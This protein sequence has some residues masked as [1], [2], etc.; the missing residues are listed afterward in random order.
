MVELRTIRFTVFRWTIRFGGTIQVGTFLLTAE[1][2]GFVYLVYLV[3]LF[4]KLIF[5]KSSINE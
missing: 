4:T 3:L 5:R 1:G 2:R